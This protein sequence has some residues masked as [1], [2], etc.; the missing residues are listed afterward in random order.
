MQQQQK[1]ADELF[2]G[3]GT[4][5]SQ[6]KANNNQP[7]QQQQHP[8]QM[9]PQMQM[10]QQ[11]QMQQQHQPIDTRQMMGNQ[12]SQHQQQMQMQQQ[13]QPRSSVNTDRTRTRTKIESFTD[14]IKSM[15]WK[16]P[17]YGFILLFV[18]I[19]IFANMQCLRWCSKKLPQNQPYGN[20]KLDPKNGAILISALIISV[21]YTLINFFLIK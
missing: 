10:Q 20:S 18:L 16:K 9:Q 8:S 6:I 4:S 15:E 13:Q 12:H 17:L 21:I 7:Q 2:Q 11:P 3:G 1:A 19:C 5:I 14:K